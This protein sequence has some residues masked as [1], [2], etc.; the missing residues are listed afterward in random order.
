MLSTTV[1]PYSFQ[2]PL[3]VPGTAIRIRTFTNLATKCNPYVRAVHE[4]VEERD[5]EI[6]TPLGVSDPCLIVEILPGY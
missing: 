3:P 1:K 6:K 2:V 5:N 4:A